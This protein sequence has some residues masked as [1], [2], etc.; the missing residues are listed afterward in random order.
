MEESRG[1]N[2]SGQTLAG[3][4]LLFVLGGVVWTLY[5]V[6]SPRL[7]P[8]RGDRAAGVHREWLPQDWRVDPDS[9]RAE[10]GESPAR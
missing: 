2:E 10:M 1:S 9:A 8:G 6:V 3:L 4:I 5:S 7:G